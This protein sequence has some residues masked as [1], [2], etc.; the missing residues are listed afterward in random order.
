MFDLNNL[1]NI[2]SNYM[3]V[4]ESVFDNF[5]KKYFLYFIKNYE[6]FTPYGEIV[7]NENFLDQLYKNIDKLNDEKLKELNNIFDYIKGKLTR[8][9]YKSGYALIL[10]KSV[11]VLSLIE[12]IKTIKLKKNQSIDNEI[13][14]EVKKQIKIL[15]DII[16][17]LKRDEVKK[18]LLSKEFTYTFTSDFLSN[19]AIWKS[20]NSNRDAYKVYKEHFVDSVKEY[21]ESDKKKF[22]LTCTNCGLEVKSSE[23]D[24]TWINKMGADTSKKT[25][26][27]W[28]FSSDIIICPICNIIY[29]C[30]PAGFTTLN[31]KGFFINNNSKMEYLRSL[32]ALLPKTLDGKKINIQDLENESYFKIAGTF[33]NASNEELINEVENI[34]IVKLNAENERRPYTFNVLNKE[35]ALCI[36]KNKNIIKATVGS[37]IK[38]TEKFYLNVYDEVMRRI[39]NNKN[40]YDLIHELLT[41]YHQEKTGLSLA[42]MV[43]NVQKSITVLKNDLKR[44]WEGNKSM[45]QDSN[46]Q[47]KELNIEGSINYLISQGYEFRTAYNES[48]KNDKKINTVTYKLLNALK[49]RNAYKYVDILIN[50]YKYI[51]DEKYTLKVPNLFGKALNN[52]ELFQSFGYAFLLGMEGQDPKPK[53]K[54]DKK[55]N[56][57]EDKK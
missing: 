36:Y 26:H 46:K 48:A 5:E 51:Q 18:I 2:D 32:N 8:N 21:L 44:K 52:D 24:M 12:K 19:V 22:K 14:I 30:I 28:N 25:A 47:K 56:E 53:D 55:N 7:S 38:V 20:T 57:V 23:F 43:F 41:L 42:S 45:E 10:D 54:S 31:K 3:K 40:L 11:D 15:L 6:D 27:Y 1:V 49:T 16:E 9:S 39:F 34:Q 35:I 13:V 4:D 33:E 29:S 17:Y 50:S 37:C